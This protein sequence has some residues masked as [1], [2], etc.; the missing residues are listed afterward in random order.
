MALA[1]K[2]AG[3]RGSPRQAPTRS[4]Y[5]SPTAEVAGRGS[6]NIRVGRNPKSPSDN[7]LAQPIVSSVNGWRSRVHHR[8]LASDPDNDPLSLF[9]DRTAVEE[10][11]APD[12]R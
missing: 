12:R 8:P 4:T 9:V 6:V 5:T 7:A 11:M 1:P 2:C 10:S 3:I